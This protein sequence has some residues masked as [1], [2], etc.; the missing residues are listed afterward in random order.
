[1]KVS[2]KLI[3][4]LEDNGVEH[5]FGLPG[6]QI[7][8]LYESLSH[9]NI[10][11]I[12]VRHEQSAAHA[13]DGYNR[14]SG[15]LGVCI[16]T[17]SPGA[18]NLVMG[19]ACAF[20]DNVPMLVIT[21][22]NS[23]D[24]KYK[25]Y[26]Q[27]FN[28]YD[29]F[30]NITIKSYDPR[31]GNEA[32]ANLIEIIQILNEYPCGPIHLNLSK[33]ILLEDYVDFEKNNYVHVYDEVISKDIIEKIENSK[34]P[35][36]ILGSG[37]HDSGISKIA[38]SNNIPVATS[39]TGKGIVSEFEKVS[40]GMLGNRGTK[41]SEY[42]LD[43]SDC[44]I[45]IGTYLSERTLKKDIYDKLIHVNIDKKVLKGNMSICMPGKLF[46]EKINFPKVNNWLEEILKIKNNEVEGIND[47]SK[48][49]RMPSAISSI[50]KYSKNSIILGD[51]GSHIIWTMLLTK[52]QKPGQLIF[53]GA[54]APMGYSIPAAI[55]AT[56]A[57]GEN[58]II[59]NGDGDFQMNIQELITIKEYN[60]P[61]T[62]CILD[63]S[64]LG[65]IKEAEKNI[66]QMEPFAVDLV[67]PDFVEIAKAYGIDGVKVS[68]KEE[69]EK[70]M[71]NIPNKPYVIE[72][73]V[74]WEEVP[75]I[76]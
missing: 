47:N 13:A 64:G 22:D 23:T 1:M 63:N 32:V 36:L 41:Q 60:L 37:A 17:A 25:D 21:G 26:F 61:I 15:K 51:A 57:T 52:C 70:V 71:S 56:M 2:D 58:I 55:G 74:K 33:N 59:I 31:D 44:V 38:I 42:A 76:N 68:S 5:V 7:L 34:R 19:V 75:S 48:P 39:F 40:L 53:S 9:S 4:I 65:F 66:Y 24:I 46:V 6:E 16:S 35:L 28:L 62:I 49:L 12:L 67:N 73:I 29:V 3:E 18:L 30:K 50:L 8:P 69:L 11:H 14:S 43:N 54:L 10:E 45:A 72:I 27:S 20:K